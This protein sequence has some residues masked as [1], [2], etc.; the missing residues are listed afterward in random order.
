MSSSAN[1]LFRSSVTRR[2]FL[3]KAAT[4]AGLL[5]LPGGLR[6]GKAAPSNKVNVALIG[7]TGRGR[8]FHETLEQETNLVALCDI[9][10]GFLGEVHQRFPRA[11]TYVDWRKCL[12]QKDIDAVVICTTDHTHAFVANWA[13]NRNLHVY[14]EKPLATSVEEVRLLRTHWQSKRGKLASQ[15]GTSTAAN[16]NRIRELIRDGAIG[17]LKLAYA[18]TNR[19][20]YRNGYW[21]A[22]GQPPAGLHWDLWLGPAP[23]HPYNPRYF[24]KGNYVGPGERPSVAAAGAVCLSWNGFRDFGTGQVGDMG[25]HDMNLLWNAVD[26][27]FPTSAVAKGDPYHPDVFPVALECQWEHPA[28]DRRGPI[29]V[30]WNQGGEMPRSP[31]AYLDLSKIRDGVMFKGTQGFLVGDFRTGSRVVLPFGDKADLSYY[32]SRR[33]EDMTASHGN[34]MTRWLEACRN[35]AVKTTAD[36]ET[37]GNMIEQNLLG[38]VAHRAGRKITYDGVTG[39]VTDYPEANAFLKKEYRKGWTLNG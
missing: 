16:H 13:M 4:G 21:P 17:E 25:S 15:V 11:K 35:P 14:C 34:S 5:I 26:A 20:V 36:F 37:G 22:A 32:R 2:H 1:P 27:T 3:Q 19:A 10:E 39:K 7:V 12:E 18:W 30:F 28:N 33:E 31:M 29:T 6:A 38:L 24:A 23:E 9:N 8:V